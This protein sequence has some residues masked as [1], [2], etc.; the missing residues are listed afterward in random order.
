LRITTLG[1]STVFGYGVGW[2]ESWPYLLERRIN[3]QRPNRGSMRVVNLGMPRDS[4]TTFVTTMDDYDYLQPDVVILY[5]G[6]N[7]LEP[8][9]SEQ[10]GSWQPTHYL[11][12]R[13][14]SPIFRWTGY[15]PLVPLVLRE[16]ALAMMH[17]GDVN[18]AYGSRE[19]VF[20]PGLATRVTAGALQATADIETAL[21][22][23]FGRLTD[24]GAPPAPSDSTCGRWSEYCGAIRDAVHA[25]RRRGRAVVVVTQPYLSDL[26]VEQQEALA[27]GLRRE[28]AGDRGVRYVNLGRLIDLHD[29]DLAYDG[30]HLT[31]MGNDRIAEAL[32]PVVLEVNP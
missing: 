27:A 17:G 3:Q 11:T 7:D 10:D 1:G 23:R 19:I 15:L 25:A 20:R 18:A 22:R 31:K 6:Y 9:K 13:H 12:W 28:F 21:E 16:K 30:V 29:H 4:A 14:Q 8:P 2:M 5:E 32:A 26:H 24:R